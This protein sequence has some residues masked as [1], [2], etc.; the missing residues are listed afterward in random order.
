[1]TEKKPPVWLLDIDGVINATATKVPDWIWPPHTWT[2]QHIDGFQIT[3]SSRVMEYLTEVHEQGLAEIRWH[4]TWQDRALHVGEVL[5]L[6]IF[7][8]EEAP[9][10]PP[11]SELVAKWMRDGLPRWW[12]YPAA[13][14]VLTLE[15][16][17]LVWTD[18]EIFDELN[19]VRRQEIAAL[20][21]TLLVCPIRQTG[22]DAGDLR[23]IR[24]QL[25]TWNR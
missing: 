13:V 11:T 20:G 18:D 23:R 4:T 25:K 12:K 21:K 9:E 7:E 24:T 17:R 16:R 22:L 15:K 10:F 1:M 8:V 5:G 3:S 14:R 6:P 19:A 2:R